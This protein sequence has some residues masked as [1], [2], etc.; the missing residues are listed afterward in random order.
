MVALQVAPWIAVLV[1][2]WAAGLP[3]AAALFPGLPDRGA[4]LA[5]PVAL[6]TVSLGAYWVGHLTFG[7]LAVAAGLGLLVAGAA[8]ALGAGPALR[9]R[10]LIGPVAVFAVAFG[11]ALAL[12]GANPAVVPRVARSSS[13]SAC[14]TPS[15]GPTGFP[16]RISGS[17]ASG[18][19]TTTAAT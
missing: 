3:V 7:P 9:P 11:F 1:A 18:C 8:L 12:R 17:P 5:L 2:L 13:I 4:A 10:H 6:A 16:R 15:S 19:A 14:S